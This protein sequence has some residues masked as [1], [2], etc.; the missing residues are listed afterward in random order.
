MTGVLARAALAVY[1]PVRAASVVTSEPGGVEEGGRFG[2][3][4]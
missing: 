2:A 3:V 1:F 4:R